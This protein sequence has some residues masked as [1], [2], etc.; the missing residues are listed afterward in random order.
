P[1][2]LDNACVFPLSSEIP[3]NLIVWSFCRASSPSRL[4]TLR[5][6]FDGFVALQ[7]RVGNAHERRQNAR[8]HQ[9][10]TMARLMGYPSLLSPFL[11]GQPRVGR[12]YAFLLIDVDNAELAPSL[13]GF[14][15]FE[16]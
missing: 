5:G 1:A 12:C 7:V 6:P 4:A 16:P 2:S 3:R 15:C 10:R 14:C 9:P 8:K 11:G 13:S